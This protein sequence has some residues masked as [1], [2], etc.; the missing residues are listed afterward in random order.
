MSGTVRITDPIGELV[1]LAE[2]KN[3]LRVSINTDDTLISDLIV[4]ARERAEDFT[5]RALLTQEWEY[6]LDDWPQ[7]S[8]I[9]LPY[10]PLQAVTDIKYYGTDDT[11]YTLDASGYIVDETS[12]PGRVVLAYQQSWPTTLLRPTKGIKIT[13]WAGYLPAT[14]PQ[15]VVQAALQIIGH[16]YENREAFVVGNWSVI[17]IP[18]TAELLLYPYRAF[19]RGEF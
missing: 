11:E 6:W 7:G 10:P 13:Y 1:S 18:M 17:S 9:E 14:T 3:H 4:A 8:M 5:R 12:L 19:W 2:V 15:A 16:F